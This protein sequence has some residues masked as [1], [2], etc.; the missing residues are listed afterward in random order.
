MLRY[1]F[2]RLQQDDTI[3]T[4]DDSKLTYRKITRDKFTSG[5]DM[6]RALKI[7]DITVR[8]KS[9]KIKGFYY[10]PTQIKEWSQKL[11]RL[12]VKSSQGRVYL[13]TISDG[14]EVIV[15]IPKHIK[16]YDDLV[17]EY[18]VGITEINRLRFVVPNFMYTMGVFIHDR[19]PRNS[20][21][22]FM[23]CEKIPGR[24]LHQMLTTIT[25]TEY[26]N[27]L[28][29][30]LIALEVGQRRCSFCHYDLHANNVILRPIK[31]PYK[32]TVVFDNK[33]YDIIADKYIP[34]II[35]YGITTI[36]TEGRTIGTN[37]YKKFG[38]YDYLIQGVDMYKFLFYSYAYSSMEQ[39]KNL[40]R[41]YGQLDP[42]QLMNASRQDMI[43]YSKEYLVKINYSKCVT[44]TPLDFIHW[45]DDNYNNTCLR[46]RD[47]DSSNKTTLIPE[48]KLQL[49]KNIQCP[50][51]FQ[52]QRYID[53]IL[54]LDSNDRTTIRKFLDQSDFV[55]QLNPYLQNLYL[56]R[57]LGLTGQYK[58]FI[59][60]FTSSIQ[61][62]TYD[63]LIRDIERTRRWCNTLLNKF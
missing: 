6:N 35:D 42:Y 15:K 19:A 31:H 29:Q 23:A 26:L 14:I 63:K 5:T 4:T 17:R 46:I 40:F 28:I 27:I 34:V 11:Q 33:S 51:L 58:T 20:C 47:R 56:I 36:Q 32:Y 37:S 25:F 52:I 24:P 44:Y 59:D 53:R 61:Y 30:I 45:I 10:I 18:F 12:K 38:M 13:C 39:I 57:Q 60:E 2:N 50:N 49:Y 1:I 62:K 41:F 55:T 43:E 48:Q 3:V 9:K 54:V 7:F 21:P 8:T 22:I 16:Q